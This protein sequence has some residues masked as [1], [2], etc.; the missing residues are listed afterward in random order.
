[1]K[2]N[3]IFLCLLLALSSCNN[4]AEEGWGYID[5]TGKMVIE[6]QYDEGKSFSEGLAAVKIERNSKAKYGEVH[7]FMII[8]ENLS[9][10]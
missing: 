4:D 5:K 10:Q 1:M 9:N 8:F 7:L 2:K 3:S 6:P